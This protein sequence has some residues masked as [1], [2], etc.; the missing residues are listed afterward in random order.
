MLPRELLPLD[1]S[2]IFAP[3]AIFA[4]MRAF[5]APRASICLSVSRMPVS[6]YFMVF[7]RPASMLMGSMICT[8]AASFTLGSYRQM[9]IQ[10]PSA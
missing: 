10:E 2:N 6:A 9:P 4:T 3:P 7:L 5:R 1:S 8:S